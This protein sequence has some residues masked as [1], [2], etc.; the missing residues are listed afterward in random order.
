MRNWGLEIFVL[1]KEIRIIKS[2]TKGENIVV[3]RVR[4]ECPSLRPFVMSSSLK[5]KK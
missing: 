2:K 5:W 4:L 3:I 1:F